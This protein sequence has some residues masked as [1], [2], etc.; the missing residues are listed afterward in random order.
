M[1]SLNSTLAGIGVAIAEV[2]TSFL[3]AALLLAIIYKMIPESKVH[4]Q[5]V[6]LASIVTGTAFTVTNY[7][8]GT[9][10]SAFTPTTVAGAA[11]SLLIILL[12]IFVLNQIVLYGAEV[13]KVYAVTVG[14]HSRK[15]LPEPL[16]KVVESIEKAGEIVEHATKED[17]VPTGVPPVKSEGKEVASEYVPE[18]QQEPADSSPKKKREKE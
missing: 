13:S 10:I 17:V 16:E 8:F 14:K 18:Q 2:V 6:A 9:Y 1:Y 3:V 15:H 5:D 4:W 12:W 7:I 11:G